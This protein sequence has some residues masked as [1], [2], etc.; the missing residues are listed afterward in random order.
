MMQIRIMRN[1]GVMAHAMARG[2]S[3][4]KT[5]WLGG[6]AGRENRLEPRGRKKAQQT[7]PFFR[8]I[9]YDGPGAGRSRAMKGVCGAEGLERKTAK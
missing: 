6:S 2:D 7:V 9:G 8:M 5:Q 3:V 4:V 1:A